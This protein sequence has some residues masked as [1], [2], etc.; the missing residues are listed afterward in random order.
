MTEQTGL[1]RLDL[2]NLVFQR[3]LFPRAFRPNGPAERS[4]GLRPQAD[5]LGKQATPL[6]AA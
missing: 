4:P 3:S 1:V 2:N 6:H 5:A